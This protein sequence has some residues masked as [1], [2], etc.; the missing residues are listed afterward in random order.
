MLRG[1]AAA[2]AGATAGKVQP[3]GQGNNSIAWL[4]V[5]RQL[6]TGKLA[7]ASA[8]SFSELLIDALS[9]RTVAFSARAPNL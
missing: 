2:A 4:T 5:Y 7:T 6:A 9:F 3:V 8:V 1:R